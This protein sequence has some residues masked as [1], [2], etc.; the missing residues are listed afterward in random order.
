MLVAALLLPRPARAS[1]FFASEL[2]SSIDVAAITAAVL[3]AL[4]ITAVEGS[5]TMD[6]YNRRSPSDP[7]LPDF[8]L[9]QGYQL[10]GTSA[11]GSSSRIQAGHAMLGA[12]FE[13]LH[14]WQRRPT[15]TLEYGQAEALVRLADRPSFG[16]NLAYGYRDSTGVRGLVPEAGIS[17]NYYSDSGFGLETD[18]RWTEIQSAAVFGDGR[19]RAVW[20]LA[21]S[22]LS[23]F[24]GYRALRLASG[25]RDGPEAGLTLTW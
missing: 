19:V 14:Y 7:V 10:V 3:G 11:Q 24:G 25:H 4:F 2:K 18:L 13:Y 16:A 8:R 20:R 22:P 5:A 12:D 6:E 23:F 15:A 21:D 17:L 1:N 9:D